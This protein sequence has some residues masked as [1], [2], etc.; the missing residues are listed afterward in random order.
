MRSPVPD[1]IHGLHCLSSIL[2]KAESYCANRK[3]DPD[4]LLKARFSLGAL[5]CSTAVRSMG[6]SER[7]DR[8]SRNVGT[9][10]DACGM[11]QPQG[12]YLF[13]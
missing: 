2:S 13:P 12:P 6:R 8:Q 7:S 11:F 9:K 1:L 4:A 10:G 5:K 3:I